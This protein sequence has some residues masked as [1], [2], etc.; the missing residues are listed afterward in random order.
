M[1]K[2]RNP[3]QD[4]TGFRV[5]SCQ[6]DK[7]GC[8]KATAPIQ[9]RTRRANRAHRL[10]HLALNKCPYRTNILGVDGRGGE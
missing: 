1:P 9:D 7:N 5:I 3:A 4:R 6:F 10:D 2:T 8:I